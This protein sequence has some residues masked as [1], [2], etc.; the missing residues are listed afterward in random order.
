MTS[1]ARQRRVR[2]WHSRV[3]MV[4]AAFRLFSTPLD[5]VRFLRLKRVRHA[6]GDRMPL[7]LRGLGGAT[8]WLRP[9]TTDAD[10]L[11]NTFFHGYHLPPA[12]LPPPRVI[13]DLGANAGYTCCHYAALFPAA[14]IVGLELDR[15]NLELAR[16]NTERL[17]DRCRIEHGAAWIEDGRV[18]YAGTAEDAFHVAPAVVSGAAP[19]LPEAPSWTL[20]T[21]FDRHG[22]D[23]IDFLKMDVEGAEGPLLTAGQSWLGAVRALKIELHGETSI[24]RAAEL[25]AQHG[26]R[27]E[28]DDRH[29]ASVVARRDREAV[30]EAAP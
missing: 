16:A 8:V 23:A 17:G 21:L 1:S 24:G 4:V 14:R 26:F 7:R 25:L 27:C 29:W 28:T 5:A 18:S 15:D 19:P 11:W 22:L 2:I 12:D 10:T 3:R 30:Q 20:R 13:V 6:T 9:G